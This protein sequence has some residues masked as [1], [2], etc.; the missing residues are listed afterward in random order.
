MLELQNARPSLLIGLQHSYLFRALEERAGSNPEDPIAKRTPLGWVVFGKPN[1]SVKALTLLPS[2]MQTVQLAIRTPMLE[3][4][5][6]HQLVRKHFT[7]DSLG[8]T[9]SLRRVAEDEKR[10]E[11][12]IER[13]MRLVNGQYEIGLFWKHDLITLPNSLPMAY[14]RLN[15]LE[16]AMAKDPDTLDWVNQ[17]IR[18]LIQKNYARIAT[19]DD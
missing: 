9:P 10:A 6:L 11:E 18:E 19:K 7:I 8:I 14:K 17:W 15:T 4:E 12:I 3:D 2:T 13:T 5:N 16:K 1:P